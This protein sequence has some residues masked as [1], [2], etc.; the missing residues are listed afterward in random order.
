MPL[1]VL[2][3]EPMPLYLNDLNLRALLNRASV[4]LPSLRFV[5]NHVATA[6]QSNR[7]AGFII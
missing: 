7:C 2:R 4:N 3:K 5:A 1:R 6:A